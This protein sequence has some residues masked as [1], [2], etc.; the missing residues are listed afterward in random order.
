M[1]K[2]P[3][4]YSHAEHHER[5]VKMAHSDERQDRGLVKKMVKKEALTGRK[6]GGAAPAGKGKPKS[7]VNVVIAPRGG[8]DHADMAPPVGAMPGPAALPSRP[9]VPV[10]PPM[11]GPAPAAPVPG[12]GAKRGGK[13]EPKKR[14]NGGPIGNVT[15]PKT[16]K[17]YDAG[18]GS[19]EGR[20]EKEKHY[21]VKAKIRDSK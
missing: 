4:T 2:S 8:P 6:Q 15:K 19:A 9:A 5:M 13:I 11:R 20:L 21:G 12:M 16:M 14:A 18:A 10:A 1:A 3:K 17:G 7:Q